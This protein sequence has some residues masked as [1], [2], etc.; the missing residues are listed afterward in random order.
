MQRVGLIYLDTAHSEESETARSLENDSQEKLLDDLEA[1]IH[2]T[3]DHSP[4][5]PEKDA[6]QDFMLLL[7]KVRTLAIAAGLEIHQSKED[8]PATKA[9]ASCFAVARVAAESGKLYPQ[10]A[11]TCESLYANYTNAAKQQAELRAR[12]STLKK[13]KDRQ[14]CETGRISPP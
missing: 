13:K 5:G 7:G 12:C 2:I 3:L 14:A 11:A 1:R 9:W 6:D 4:D 10:N 8:G